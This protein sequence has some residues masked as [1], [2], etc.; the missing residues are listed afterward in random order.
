MLVPELQLES[1][2]VLKAISHE[3]RRKI[4]NLIS[5]Y[6]FLSYT[7]LLNELNLSTGKLNFHLKQLS[8][9]IEKDSE[10]YYRLTT[11]GTK[12][13]D[14]LLK[15]HMISDEEEE[16]RKFEKFMPTITVRD[17]D[18]AHETKKRWYLVIFTLYIPV[19]VLLIL[20]NSFVNSAY[21]GILVDYP[22][23]LRKFIY[24]L[25]SIGISLPILAMILFLTRKFIESL[26]YE[27][28][29]TEI[30]IRKGIITRSRVIIPFRTIT[31]LV[32]K[33]APYERLL[34]LSSLIIQ[35]AGEGG[36]SEPEGKIIGLYYPHDLVEEIMNLVR[37]LDPPEYLKE[38]IPLSKTPQSIR[39]LYTQILEQLKEMKDKLD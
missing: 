12:A 24:T 6:T 1:E 7:D 27:I 38:R 8:A 34:G 31:N 14:V 19:F 17:F 37:L 11:I 39:F 30:V 4:L 20:V 36:T 5:D 3:L 25:I 10:G 22:Q 35:T 9:L 23:P 29:D 15:I 21:L 26:H 28:Y 2:W 18:P 13:M 32:V 16:R 33:R